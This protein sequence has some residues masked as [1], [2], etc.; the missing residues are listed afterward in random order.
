VPLRELILGRR[1]RSDEEAVEQVGPLSAVPVMGLDA[2]ASAAYGPEAAMTVLL[3]L[4]HAASRYVIGISIAVTAVLLAVYFS[5]R[6]TIAAYPDGGGAYT[7][8]KENLGRLPGLLAATA[9]CV[10]YVLNVAVAISAGVGA[11][12]S[13]VPSLLP[14]TL[15]LCLLILAVLTVVNL[16]GVRSAG[17]AFLVP[18]YLF[19][20]VVGVVVV[21]GVTRIL[22]RGHAPASVPPMAA[23][24][25][26]TAAT[27]LLLRSFASGCTALTGVEAVSNAVPAFREPRVVLARRTLTAIVAILACLLLGGAV[28][29]RLYGITAR[30]PLQAGYESVLSQVIAA[31]VGRGPGYYLAIA[32]VLLVLSLSADTSFTD[33][34]RV[35]R[36]LALD[37]YLP[38]GFAHRGRRLIYTQGI[39][40]LAT[41]SAILLLAFRGVTDRL[42]P[43]FAVGAFTAFTLS[44]LGMVAHWRR[45]G[46][47]Y[48]RH[49]MVANGVGAAATALT[50]AIIVVSKFT[51][52]AW[53]TVL[54][55]PVLLLLFL[56]YRGRQGRLA[57]KLAPLQ[58][59]D[60]RALE[61]PLVVVPLQRLDRLTCR[62]LRLGL[63][64]SPEVEAV[65]VLA[66]D[67]K[68]DDLTSRWERLVELPMRPTGRPP[69]R[70]VVLASPY[71]EQI[72]PLIDH[73]LALA[74]RHRHRTIAVVVP[75]LVE[76]RWYHFI[77]APGST[78]LT[79]LIVLRG[80][81]RIAVVNAPWYVED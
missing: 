65:Q 61:P 37:E 57:R 26:G 29:S 9:L 54:S 40:V 36:L 3:P 68:Q 51:E 38:P 28:L 46:G 17:I 10:D 15:P 19:V 39:L 64:I 12:V 30:P 59:L 44:Q 58:P 34:P 53:L 77:A 24:A 66:E 70:L 13:A 22:L 2:L 76:R 35:C 50:L 73:V 79:Q 4:G 23:P 32:S 41:L 75:E 8:A 7:V 72:G 43:L 1:L 63:S 11:L 6:Q 55:F 78:I 25:V 49:S 62:A 81:S 71:R 48:A 20:A 42:I 31:V 18:T 16:R 56:R 60:P 33:F 21:L 74:D 47:R 45:T 69:P 14:R 5:Y 80:H 27:W 52:G 67:L